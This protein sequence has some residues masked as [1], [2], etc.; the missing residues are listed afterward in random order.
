MRQPAAI[1]GTAVVMLFIVAMWIMSRHGYPGGPDECIAL[2]DCYCE[3]IG[4][5][6]AAQAANAWSNAGFVTIGLMVLAD[7]GRRSGT[8]RMTRDSRAAWLYGAVTIFL[9]IG[10]FTFHGSM[11]AW[12]GYAD[13][14]SM[15]ASSPTSSR[16]ISTE[17]TG[18]PGVDSSRASRE[19][20]PHSQL[21][22]L[23]SHRSTA[24]HCSPCSS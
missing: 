23:S 22:S 14:L 21:G 11:R 12:G 15:H 9:G 3:A 5:G 20:S 2:S 8:D 13:V 18:G 24:K 17:S 7:A 10:S 1:I 4:P 19:C 16:T 6:I